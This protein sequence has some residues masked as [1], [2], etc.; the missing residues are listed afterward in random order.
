MAGPRVALF[1]KN[2]FIFSGKF[3]IGS[4]HLSVPSGAHGAGTYLAYA[5]GGA[6][7]YRLAKRVFAR[8]DY[9][10]QI[11]PSFKGAQTGRGHGG[12]TPNGLSVGVS[13]AIFR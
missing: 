1:H 4:A 8:V 13:Y 12:L 11:W 5:P 10:Y 6:I 2:K 9:E 3:M 7:D